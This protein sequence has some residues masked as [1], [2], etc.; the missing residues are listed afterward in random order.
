M[1]I[2]LETLNYH[3]GQGVVGSYSRNA[4]AHP[5]FPQSLLIQ[6]SFHPAHAMQYK[7]P[8]EEH[9]HMIWKTYLFSDQVKFCRK[10]PI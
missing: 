4:M 6:H 7:S 1:K 10:L 2:F 3:A 9:I 8:L 5:G